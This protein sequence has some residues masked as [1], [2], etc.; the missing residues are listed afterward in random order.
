V[1]PKLAHHR[2]LPLSA[3]FVSLALLS[4]LL[5]YGRVFNPYT[6]V[7]VIIQYILESRANDTPKA[8]YIMYIAPMLLRTISTQ[9]QINL[10]GNSILT[11]TTWHESG[12]H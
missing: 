1:F 7:V 3:T 5:D 6:V 11:S 8:Q 2:L 9:T 10:F 4:L 12:Y